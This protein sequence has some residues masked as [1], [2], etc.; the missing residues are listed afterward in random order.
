[1]PVILTTMI[2]A[3]TIAGSDPTGGAGIQADLKVFKRF[4]ILGLSVIA[5]LTAQDT[6]GV[7]SV[8]AVAPSFIETQLT[9]LF[10]DI[11][12]RA[13]KTGMLLTEDAVL[14][15]VRVLREFEPGLIIVD[16]VLVSSSGKKLLSGS[17]Y[18]AMR[19]SLIPIAHVVT[20]N[21]PEASALTGI[22]IRDENDIE[23]AALALHD[24]GAGAVVIKGGHRVENN[25]G[26]RETTVETVY[27]GERFLRIHGKRTEGEYHGTGCAFSAA[28]AALLA[29]GENLE[30][31]VR[32]A[33][34]FIDEAIDTATKPGSGMSLLGL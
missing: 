6:A 20:P 9:V 27:D 23:K 5:A 34:E 28:L 7:K 3:L 18:S 31:A 1:M 22:D 10:R 32:M 21:I 30:T 8:L 29:L 13:V 2:S 4:G 19:S 12:P 11:R 15:V 25:I 14:T 16:P 33:K 26:P 17:G 24:M